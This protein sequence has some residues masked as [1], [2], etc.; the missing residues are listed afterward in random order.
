MGT[1]ITLKYILKLMNL[2]MKIFIDSLKLQQN[3]NIAK[4]KLEILEPIN[5][6]V[7]SFN[8]KRYQKNGDIGI[9]S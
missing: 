3:E 5:Y 7:A 6:R 4:Q 8:F 1:L 9:K 2:S